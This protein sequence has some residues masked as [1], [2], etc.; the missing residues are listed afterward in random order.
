MQLNTLATGTHTAPVIVLLADTFIDQSVLPSSGHCRQDRR[1]FCLWSSTIITPLLIA[2]WA[3]TGFIS[4]EDDDHILGSN[5]A[6]PCV[7]FNILRSPIFPNHRHPFAKT[8]YNHCLC[9]VSEWSLTHTHSYTLT[10]DST[11]HSE[12]EGENFVDGDAKFDSIPVASSSCF[13]GLNGSKKSR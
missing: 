5:I 2:R 8:V 3:S 11:V 13:L 4:H 6:S 1:W 7:H 10:C 12:Y 9:H